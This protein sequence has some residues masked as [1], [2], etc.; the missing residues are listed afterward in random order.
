VSD[1]NREG[2]RTARERLR[3]QREQEQQ[4]TRRT[5]RLVAAGATVGVLALAGVTGALISHST[6][7]GSGN[8]ASGAPGTVPLGATGKDDLV[9]P[10]GA[11]DAPVTLTV[12]EDFRCP[13]C[14]NFENTY[15]SALHG[16]EDS[17]R[18]RVD[19][20]LVRIIDGNLGGTGSLDGANAAGCAQDQG[21]FREFHDALYEH[22]PEE[23]DDAFAAPKRLLALA[24]RVDG[25]K[26]N[27]VFATCVR[28]GRYDDWVKRSNAAFGSSGF[29]A[30]PTVLLGGK[31]VYS[32]AS[33][34]LTPAKLIAKVKAA[35]RGKPLGTVRP[36]A[37]TPTG[38][39]TPSRSASPSPSPS[40]SRTVTASPA[41]AP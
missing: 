29:N 18:L 35:G 27:T 41:T 38:S 40:D 15:R 19:Y 7:H 5:R 24:S 13:A 12:Y 26:D 9:I 14:D 6:S 10:V 20:H 25:L 30:T 34:P 32:D 31:N 22:Q 8:G 37:A 16:L 2:K 36:A 17:G 28:S 1:K 23:T 11:A 3:E 33:D 21:L 39:A 4:R